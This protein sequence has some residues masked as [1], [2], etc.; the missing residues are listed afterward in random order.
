MNFE[1]LKRELSFKAVRSSGAGGQ[2]VNKVSSK[3]VLTFD[4]EHSKGIA[5]EE[6][7]RIIA[8]LKPRLTTN[9]VLMLTCDSSRVQ[10]RNKTKVTSRF[11]DLIKAANAIP[12]KRIK[13]K[14]SK[15]VKIKRLKAKKFNALK[16]ENRKK[17]NLD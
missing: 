16:K 15:S 14:M 1:I 11:F 12:K 17:P 9:N 2:H 8:F 4:L 7:Q 10:S 6:K 3:V 13:T 5:E